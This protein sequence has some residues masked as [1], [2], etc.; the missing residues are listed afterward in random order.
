[1]QPDEVSKA[2]TKKIKGKKSKEKVKSEGKKSKGSVKSEGK[3]SKKSSKSKE[4]KSGSGSKRNK[5]KKDLPVQ[6]LYYHQTAQSRYQ[7]VQVE[8][9]L[10]PPVSIE[11]SEMVAISDKS[12]VHLETAM[13]V[14]NPVV[15]PLHKMEDNEDIVKGLGKSSK[16]DCILD[17]SPWEGVLVGNSILEVTVTFRP[18]QSVK[19]A[20]SLMCNIEGGNGEVI[21]IN[22]VSADLSYCLDKTYVDFGR[23]VAFP[24][25]SAQFLLELIIGFL[26]GCY[27]NTNPNKHRNGGL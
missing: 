4:K 12:R 22:A 25:F 15:I 13:T 24:T 8:E 23:Q 21:D 17:V 6:T 19:V 10:P 7:Y 16:S 5:R 3:R 2:K 26:R 11:S 14:L 1:M 27:K 20:A 9:D 18:R